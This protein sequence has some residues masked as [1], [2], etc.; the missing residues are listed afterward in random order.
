M[1]VP[2][3]TALQELQIFPFPSTKFRQNTSCLTDPVMVSV[4]WECFSKFQAVRM[5][6]TIIISTLSLALS[7]A[8]P[9]FKGQLEPRSLTVEEVKE[10]AEM[11]ITSL[12]D[13][14]SLPE[15]SPSAQNED[16]AFEYLA[17]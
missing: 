8:I 12:L 13:K 4:P 7:D 1:G 11:N 10:G 17:L 2:S 5:S 9:Q 15:E 14:T 3:K 16:V 6:A